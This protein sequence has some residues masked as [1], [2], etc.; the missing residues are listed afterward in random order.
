MAN[1]RLYIRCSTCGKVCAIGKHFMGPWYLYDELEERLQQF[2]NDH[3]YCD[4]YNK[5]GDSEAAFNEF[6]LVSEMGG[7]GYPE[8]VEYDSKYHTKIKRSD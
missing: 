7:Y 4:D 1:N 8:I 6:E 5:F 2:F 3:V